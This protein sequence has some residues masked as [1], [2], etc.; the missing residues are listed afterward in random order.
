MGQHANDALDAAL[1]AAY[2]EDCYYEAYDWAWYNSWPILSTLAVPPP[3]PEQPKSAN[4][5]I[6]QIENVRRCHAN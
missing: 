5:I 6:K 4:D 2:D 1:N 3:P